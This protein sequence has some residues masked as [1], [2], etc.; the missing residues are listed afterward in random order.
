VVFKSVE[1]RP[2]IAR[3]VVVAF[4]V[5]AFPT[6]TKLPLI[7]D[8]A[9]DKN[10]EAS[11]EIPVTAR[12]PVAVT[13]PAMYALPCTDSFSN[14]DVV[15]IPTLLEKYDLPDTSNIDASV[16]VALLPTTTTSVVSV[17]YKKISLVLVDHAPAPPPPPDVKSVPHTGTPPATLRTVPGAPTGS[18]VSVFAPEAYSKSPVAYEV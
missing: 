15:A 18:L 8:D 3:F 6:T 5:V 11:V 7:V 17:G 4:V 2:V 9:S 13:F 12:V 16:A 10:P 14:G 1:A